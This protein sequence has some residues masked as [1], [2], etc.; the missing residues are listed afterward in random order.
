MGL[1][2]NAKL[3]FAQT[4]SGGATNSTFLALIPKESNPSN[5]SRFRPISLCNSSY[6][7]LTKI[8]VNRLTPLLT[9]LI[10]ENQSGFLRDKQITDNI[11]LVQEAIHSSK[12]TKTPGMVVKLDMENAFDRVKHSFLFSI[13]KAYGFS[14]NFSNWI[15]ACI[16]TPWVSPLLNGR[17]TNFF[18]ASRGLRQGCPLSPFLYIL[19]ADSLSRKLEEERRKGK[20]PGLLIARGVKEINHSQFADDTLLLGSTTIRT[21][22]RFQKILSSFLTASGG[23]LNIS[24]CRIYGWHVPGH[25]KEQI[26]RIFGFPIITTWNYFKYLGMPIFLNSY[27]SSAWLEIVEKISA[28]IQN[29]GGRWLNPAGKTILIKSV[30]SSLSIF[31]CSGLLAPKGIL[32]KISRALR[33]FLWAG[34]KTNTKKFHLINWKQ[35]CQPYNKGGLAIKDPAIMNR[36]LGAKL[37]WRLTTGKSDWW[38]LALLNKY[39]QTSR[40]RCLDGSIPTLPGS[41]I[42]RLLKNV[43]PL[44]QAKLSWAPGNGDTIN[45]WSDRIL[46]HEPLSSHVTL[47]PLKY[48]CCANGF[49]K[50]QDFC[51]WSNDGDWVNWKSPNPPEFLNPLLPIFFNNLGWLCPP[52]PLHP[53]LPKLG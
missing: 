21:A 3:H 29:W 47:Q 35:I 25:I 37:A 19:L 52:Q 18:K 38:K 14:E 46:N 50:L 26:A 4:E 34:G 51:L 27:G 8:I 7:I 6:K 48:W 13:L 16:S 33:C 22:N 30:L 9:K 44:I 41:P 40:L 42:W 11:V 10:S 49:S 2:E 45:I 31:Q 39:F 23:K 5:F 12:K 28:R 36:S 1:E 15:K 43:A 24:K 53:R 20:L 17:P 32:E